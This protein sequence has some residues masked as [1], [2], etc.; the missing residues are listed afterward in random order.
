MTEDPGAL[1]QYHKSIREHKLNESAFK[2][3][4]AIQ[5]KLEED[6]TDTVVEEQKQIVKEQE[7]NKE[8]DEL[9][10]HLLS[11][12]IEENQELDEATIKRLK[13]I[14]TNFCFKWN[15]LKPPRAHHCSTCGRWIARMDHH[16]PWMNNWIGIRN[17]KL[18]L[19]LLAYL[20]I[21]T[22]FTLIV[23]F[24]WL[25]HWFSEKWDVFK[26]EGMMLHLN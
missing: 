7:N 17:I 19:V 22:S 5:G 4:Q 3:Y 2:Y 11:N 26:F 25:F 12:D 6:K 9:K 8:N 1:P 16:C 21:G 14:F 24:F 15:S 10:K 23:D 20:A 13:G 18:F